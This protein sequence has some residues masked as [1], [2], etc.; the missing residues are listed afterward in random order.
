[1]LPER[2]AVLLKKSYDGRSFGA[3]AMWRLNIGH[4]YLGALHVLLAA[5]QT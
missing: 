2:K 1:M 5:L 4:E 3:E